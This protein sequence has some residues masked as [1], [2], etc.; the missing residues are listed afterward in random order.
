AEKLVGLRD[1]LTVQ[2]ESVEDA[3]AAVALLRE[4]KEIDGK[5]VFVVGH[6]LGAIVAP[7]IGSLEPAVAGLG[8]LSGRPPPP[9]DIILEHVTYIV[10][11]KGKPTDEDRKE[12]D[13]LREQV[14]RVKDPK[15]TAETPRTDL[16]LCAPAAYWLAL[17]AYDVAATA[18]KFDRPILVLQGE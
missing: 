9:R 8:L 14:A 18:A 13:K 12:L 7:R 10:A 1:K 17:R 11:L 4:Q 2:E 15:L 16:P 3:V 5:R 6:S